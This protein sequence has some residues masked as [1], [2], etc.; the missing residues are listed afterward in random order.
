MQQCD[1]VGAGHGCADLLEEASMIHRRGLVVVGMLASML[2]LGSLPARAEHLQPAAPR[3]ATRVVVAEDKTEEADCR[4]WI[5][6]L[7]EERACD[8][9]TVIVAR[10]TTYAT[11]GAS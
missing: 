6:T 10:M 5:D 4:T 2:L 7:Q 9:G 8:P 11:N 3:P 1:R